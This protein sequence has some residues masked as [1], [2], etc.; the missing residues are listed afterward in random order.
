MAQQRGDAGG[1]EE[2]GDALVMVDD[3]GLAFLH[4]RQ[5]ERLAGDPDAVDRELCCARWNSSQDSSSALEGMQPAFRQV[6]PKALLPSRFFHS[7]IQ[8]T[9]SLF[10][11][12]RIAAG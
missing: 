2:R 9:L 11:A 12:A 10:C 1:L 3:S 8:A 5:I 4:L 6:P 7:S